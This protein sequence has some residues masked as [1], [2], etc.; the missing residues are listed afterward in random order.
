MN[1]KELLEMLIEC[2]EESTISMK[3]ATPSQC[4]YARRGDFEEDTISFVSPQMLVEA[5]KARLEK[6]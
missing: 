2:V 1:N 4:Y 6:E 5:L 3:V